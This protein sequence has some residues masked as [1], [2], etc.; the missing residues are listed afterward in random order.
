MAAPA[1]KGATA[2]GI[3]SEPARLSSHG[4]PVMTHSTA[5]TTASSTLGVSDKNTVSNATAAKNTV[6]NTHAVGSSTTHPLAPQNTVPLQSSPSSSTSHPSTALPPPP[7]P[8]PPNP[9]L[10][11]HQHLLTQQ[12]KML[13][14]LYPMD[15]ALQVAA[16]KNLVAAAAAA[17]PQIL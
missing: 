7:P 9:V 13:P 16:A 14:Y 8:P 1:K 3:V 2:T 12:L 11:K 4:A 10:V 17:C 5:R 15:M 6:K